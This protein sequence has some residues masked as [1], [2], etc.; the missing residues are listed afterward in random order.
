MLTDPGDILGTLT[1]HCDRLERDIQSSIKVA[2]YEA[3][4]FSMGA[5]KNAPCFCC[6]YNGPNYYDPTHHPCA[7]R[8]HAAVEKG[9][10]PC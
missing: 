3:L 7:K 6:G 5:M 8:H 2:R 1:Y 4:L 9:I 10:V